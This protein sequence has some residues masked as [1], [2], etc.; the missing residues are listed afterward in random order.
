MTSYQDV[1]DAFLSQILDDEWANWTEEEVAQDLKTLLNGAIP[2]FKFPRVSL[3]TN[4]NGFVETLSNQEIQILVSYM[5]CGWLNRTIL[6]WEHVKPKYEERDFSEA[7]LIDKL[8]QLLIEEKKNAK[9]LESL[10]YRSINAK[11]YQYR[12]LAGDNYE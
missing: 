1:Y 12:K 11:P 5:K 3:E 6:S 2:K 10:Y 9:S 4:N 7:N 8:N